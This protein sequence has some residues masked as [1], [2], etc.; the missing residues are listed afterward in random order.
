M[1]RIIITLFLVTA[2]SASYAQNLD[3]QFDSLKNNSETFKQYKVIDISK[4]NKFWSITTD[5]VKN[6]KQ[7]IATLQ[8]E[9][10][11]KSDEISTLNSSIDEKDKRIEDLES[12][13][14]TI[15]V[16]GIDI[17]KSTYIFISFFTV[18]AL[19][20]VLLFLVYQFKDNNK[21]ARQKVKEYDKLHDEFEEYKRQALEKQMKLRRDLQTERNKLEEARNM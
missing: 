17:N 21:T 4:L 16:F 7:N 14:S 6:L 10:Q 18:G 12:Q 15:E 1:N 11:A 13:T 2:I 8:K 9:T 20:I 3:Y 19:V 5:S